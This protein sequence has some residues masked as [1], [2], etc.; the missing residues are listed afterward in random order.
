VSRIRYSVVLRTS[1]NGTPDASWLNFLS[2]M[3]TL[4]AANLS[5]G[6][7]FALFHLGEGAALPAVKGSSD[8]V[9]LVAFGERS[10]S[11][12][13]AFDIWI[14]VADT[15]G[16]TH[17]RILRCLGPLGR[18]DERGEESSADPAAVR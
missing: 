5:D 7:D 10:L 15:V 18:D 4:R 9:E 3:E 16:D 13:R 1:A 2:T 12:L 14:Q 17:E 6:E 8:G 11:R